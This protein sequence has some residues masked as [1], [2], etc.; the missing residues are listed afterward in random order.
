M[1]LK[2]KLFP[3]KVNARPYK[4]KNQMLKGTNHSLHNLRLRVS[5][6]IKVHIAKELESHMIF[7][8]LYVCSIK[9]A[10]KFLRRASWSIGSIVHEFIDSIEIFIIIIMN[11]WNTKCY[12]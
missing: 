6:G 4:N 1:T 10:F 12:E 9:I 3:T 2:W 8:A 11:A 7:Y 5:H